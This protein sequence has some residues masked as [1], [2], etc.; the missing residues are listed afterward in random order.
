M[1]NKITTSY[2]NS[3]QTE[4]SFKRLDTN[5][6]HT[7]LTNNNIVIDANDQD[8]NLHK[9]LMLKEILSTNNNIDQDT[10]LLGRGISF[11]DIKELGRM[12][13]DKIID[14]LMLEPSYDNM[15]GNIPFSNYSMQTYSDWQDLVKHNNIQT[16]YLNKGYILL[17]F[18]N[19]DF[20]LD[21]NNNNLIALNE[22]ILDNHSQSTSIFNI[23]EVKDNEKTGRSMI[24]INDNCTM[25]PHLKEFIINIG[26]LCHYQIEEIL[27]SNIKP[28]I[29]LPSL[30]FTDNRYIGRQEAHID[31]E[32]YDEGQHIILFNHNEIEPIYLLVY[33]GSHLYNKNDHNSGDW[34]N[35]LV[36]R[37]DSLQAVIINPLLVHAGWYS[38]SLNMSSRLH[39]YTN[40]PKN[41]ILKTHFLNEYFKNK[42]NGTDQSISSKSNGSIGGQG[43]TKKANSKSINSKNQSRSS[44]GKFSSK[45]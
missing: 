34:F 21:N 39:F 19:D 44:D 22:Y 29:V 43:L 42:I 5:D 3:L 30:L 13:L 14:L 12:K 36:V 24:S 16:L 18:N 37:L 25:N 4:E 31:V 38:S 11:N 23:G 8:R 17:D 33:P 15:I 2:W 41:I 27:D 40:F 35:P 1:G 28:L 26:K 45:K 7:F 20:F 32:E 9:Y 10:L 6:I